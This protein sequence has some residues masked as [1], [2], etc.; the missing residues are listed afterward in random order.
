[1]NVIL[2]ERR[3]F[4]FL[5][6]AAGFARY[7]LH[8]CFEVVCFF[9]RCFSFSTFHLLGLLQVQGLTMRSLTWNQ[10]PIKNLQID[11]LFVSHVES[12]YLNAMS[13]SFCSWLI[14]I[15][16]V[17]EIPVFQ[18]HGIVSIIIYLSLVDHKTT[19]FVWIQLCI[20][21]IFENTCNNSWT[22][23][24]ISKMFSKELRILYWK[25]YRKPVKPKPWIDSFC[26][27]IKQWPNI[28]FLWN[29]LH[30]GSEQS[31][32][33]KANSSLDLDST[34]QLIVL[35]VLSNVFTPTR[36]TLDF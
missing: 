4:K 16:C 36:Q 6:A 34:P 13:F 32:H 27:I 22:A 35:I 8:F 11:F 29:Q 9:C 7:S 5:L 28:D 23:H 24:P 1:M 19:V 20:L 25:M 30:T 3:N 31:W 2:R 15:T 33:A 26:C 10:F 17:F 14:N 12:S 18:N 21:L